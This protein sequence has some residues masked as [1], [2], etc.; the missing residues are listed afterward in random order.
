MSSVGAAAQDDVPPVQVVT[1]DQGVMPLRRPTEAQVQQNDGAVPLFC[2]FQQGRQLS[3]QFVRDETDMAWTGKHFGLQRASPAR[4]E[5][6]LGH[7][8][9]RYGETCLVQ[10]H[11]QGSRAAKIRLLQDHGY[12]AQRQLPFA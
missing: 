12:I 5:H 3:I 6:F 2:R 10:R 11:G 9:L 8:V 4:Q 1:D 7:V